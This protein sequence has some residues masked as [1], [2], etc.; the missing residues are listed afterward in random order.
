MKVCAQ[1]KW[2]IASYRDIKHAIHFQ[3]KSLVRGCNAAAARG[4]VHVHHHGGGCQI[5]GAELIVR[6]TM[7]G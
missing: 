2:S 3:K 5:R 1:I 7:S 4:H 6:T